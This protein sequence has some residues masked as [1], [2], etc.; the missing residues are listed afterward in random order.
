MKRVFK[1]FVC[2]VVLLNFMMLPVAAATNYADNYHYRNLKVGDNLRGKTLYFDTKYDLLSLPQ[3][4]V[5]FILINDYMSDEVFISF[6]VNGNEDNNLCI[7]D[8]TGEYY[9][10]NAREWS[11]SSF[12]FSNEEDFIITKMTNEFEMIYIEDTPFNQMTL[13]NFIILG[14]ICIVGIYLIFK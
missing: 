14:L 13:D 9:V 11:T 5:N 2:L 3:N 10:L 7:D 1:I 8:N 12:K 4:E 6:Y